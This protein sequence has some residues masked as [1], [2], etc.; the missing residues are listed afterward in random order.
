MKKHI[1]IT[2]PCSEDRSKMTPTEAGVFC[3]KCAT[4]VYDFSQLSDVEIR[5][6]LI[7]KMDA[8]VCA[9][10][11]NKQE[12]RL[13]QDFYDW[14]SSR[15]RHMQKAML[16]SLIAVFGLTLF[17]CTSPKEEASIVEIQRAIQQSVVQ[18]FVEEAHLNAIHEVEVPVEPEVIKREEVEPLLK[19]DLP[20]NLRA[21]DYV[22]IENLEFE[23]HIMI[24]GGM[25]FSEDYKDYLVQQEIFTVEN[26]V[27]VELTK[28]DLEL[29]IFPNPTVDYATLTVQTPVKAS[30][31]IIRL[32]DLQGK[33][34]SQI[35]DGPAK[36]GERSFSID[37]ANQPSGVYLIVVI[38]DDKKET[39]RLVR[40]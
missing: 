13:N 30:K 35:Y 36:R 38:T 10:I 17:S 4:E 21:E 7:A 23:P 15:Q 39:V 2:N 20:I 22:V 8:S 18:S 37:V 32:V 19:K 12:E 6:V 31:Q 34:V 11:T 24:D 29:T 40:N 25:R 1:G 28:N 16:F 26:P 9:R 33:I 27:P 14:Q 5:Q 3:Q